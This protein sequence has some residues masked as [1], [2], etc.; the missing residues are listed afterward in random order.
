[1]L[2]EQSVFSQFFKKINLDN[3]V[4]KRNMKYTVITS[5]FKLFPNAKFRFGFDN[6]LLCFSKY[7]YSEL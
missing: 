2:C 3:T 6:P 7:M 1:M 4:I 5:I